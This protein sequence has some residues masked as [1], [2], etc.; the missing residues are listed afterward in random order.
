MSTQSENNQIFSYFMKHKF[1]YD[2]MPKSAKIVVF[3]TQLLVSSTSL[4]IDLK[5]YRCLKNFFFFIPKV[6][7]AFF[8]LIYNGVRAAPLWDS[9][10][11][12]FVG[13]LTITDFILILQKYYKEAHVIDLFDYFS[14]TLKFIVYTL[15][16]YE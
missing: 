7:K 8:A 3:D 13:M 6:K 16:I 12:K 5:P 10:N 2:I 15:L 9:K 4:F 1:C 14:L 11:Q